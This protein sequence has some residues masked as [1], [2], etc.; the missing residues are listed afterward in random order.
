M[1]PAVLAAFHDFSRPLEGRVP[2]MYL[3]NADPEGLVTVG[4]GNLIDPISEAVR[5]PFVHADGRRASTADIVADWQRVK[6]RQD[7]KRYGGMVFRNVARLRL[8]EHAIDRLVNTKLSSFDAQL[9]QLF[10]DW[11][12]W[13]CDTQLAL[14]SWAW[15]VGA[16]A[17][18]PRMIAHLRARDFAAAAT[19]CTINPQ[20][21][22]IVTR[23]LHNRVLLSNAAVVESEGLDPDVLYW[24]RALQDERATE[25]ELPVYRAEAEPAI[26]YR[27]PYQEPDDEPPEAA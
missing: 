3:D 24:P 8:Q 17:K 10:P 27:S 18:Y 21:G 23:N 1:R 11:D 5:L 15:A 25:P 6:A 26:V 19:E 20:R 12:T 14:L 16:G 7:L 4:V 13:C 22:T 2:F 9:A